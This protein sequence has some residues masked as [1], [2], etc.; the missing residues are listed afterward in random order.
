[1]KAVIALCK[2]NK[3]NDTFGIRF[4]SENNTQWHY[5]WAFPIKQERA[6]HEG[7]DNTII[8]GVFIEDPE[9]PGCPYCKA[10]GFYLCSCG[11]L[12]CWD[13]EKR[14]VICSWCNNNGELTNSLNQINIRK[15]Y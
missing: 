12:N 1:M 14:H 5:T 2:C 8:K 10:K 9:Y 13:G 4:Q 6:K 15:N 7:Y 11:K 3:K